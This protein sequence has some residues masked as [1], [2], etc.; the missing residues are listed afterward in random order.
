MSTELGAKVTL[1]IDFAP[2]VAPE[3]SLFETTLF[4][5]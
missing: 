4:E 3:V 2:F 1:L 5:G